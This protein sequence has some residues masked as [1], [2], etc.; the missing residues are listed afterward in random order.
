MI[1]PARNR[2]P[3]SWAALVL[4]AVFCNTVAAVELEGHAHESL[5]ID[6]T[7]TLGDTIDAAVAA[8]PGF[9]VLNARRNE[10]DAWNK[11]GDSW[12]AGRPS[13]ML[14]YQSDRWGSAAGLDEYEAGIGMPLWS[15]GGRSAVQTF[16]EALS[17]ESEAAGNA[18]RW[19]VAGLVRM[20]LWNVA[21]ADN[22]HE[23]A[24]QAL[25]TAE[26]MARLVERRHELGD[27]ALSDVLLARSSYLESQT[28]LIEANSALLDAERAYRS[29]TGLDR[30]PDFVPETLSDAGD[31]A[32]G[33]PALALSDAAVARAEADVE[34]AENTAGTGAN[35][36]IGSRRERP[37]FGTELDDSI[38][39][40]VNVPFGGSSHRNTEISAAA[41]TASAA[42]AARNQQLRELT[43]ALHE[44]AHGLNV[45]HE[46]L[47]AAS[48]RL[49]LAQ[50]HQAMGEIAYEKGEIELIDLLKIQTTTIAA[51]RQVTR[52]VIDEKRQ[53]ALYNQAV[54][55]LP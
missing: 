7:L 54:G 19:E 22:D 11:R 5:A 52:L 33:H 17:A 29:I 49:E 40:T 9:L 51:R 44:A 31:I 43:L 35:V 55:Q 36:M 14:R 1:I 27:V 34:V 45:V 24:E 37:A 28:A 12:L 13:L 39:V 32:P 42:K 2:N 21:L 15:W 20:A 47:A 6:P 26:H 41:R 16:G 4:A 30:R 46:N 3:L 18:L 25:D 23:I 38:G 50:R 48:E 53:T 8:Y 10:A